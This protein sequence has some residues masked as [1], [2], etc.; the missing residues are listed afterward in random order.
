MI[1][2]KVIVTLVICLVSLM[3]FFDMH[4]ITYRDINEKE[5]IGIIDDRISYTVAQKVF[6]KG[7]YKES[8]SHGERL[9]DYLESKDFTGK[10]YYFSAESEDGVITSDY[11]I[12][13]LNWMK[14]NGVTNV[15]VSLSS[16]SY[17]QELADWIIQ[18][19]EV[20]L[21]CSYNNKDN[22]LDYP[23]MLEGTI[24]SGVSDKI[25]YKQEDRKYNSNSIIVI[26]RGIHFYKGNSYLSLETMLSY[27]E[28]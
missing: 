28:Y 23:A 16:K 12:E 13:G 9:L 2:R 27:E 26:N 1:K 7:E 25:M 10:I 22:T 24:S 4:Y 15:N 17:N 5:I 6:Y 19:S 20:R 3:C 8:E 14:E 21:F 11:I 18:N